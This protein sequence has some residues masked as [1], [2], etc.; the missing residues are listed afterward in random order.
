MQHVNLKLVKIYFQSKI[1][2]ILVQ[3]F[4]G[5][6]GQSRTSIVRQMGKQLF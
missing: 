3:I 2:K 5:D 1:L 4:V 6:V